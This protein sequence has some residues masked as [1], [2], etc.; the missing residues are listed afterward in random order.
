MP[1]NKYKRFLSDGSM[2]KPRTTL[3][4]QNISKSIDKNIDN[5]STS[6]QTT[7]VHPTIHSEAIAIEISNI[8]FDADEAIIVK[9]FLYLR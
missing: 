3:F 1:Y 6:L 4:R 7:M 5:N 9:F 8:S 2:K